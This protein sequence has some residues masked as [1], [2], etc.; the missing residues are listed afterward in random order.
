MT[1]IERRL[2]LAEALEKNAR[3]P[4]GMRFDLSV[5]IDGYDDGDNLPSRSQDYALDCGTVG[6]AVGLAMLLPEFRAEG[7][8]IVNISPFFEN[9]SQWSAVAKFFGVSIEEAQHLFSVNAYDGPTRGA[10][11]EFAVAK[12]LRESCVSHTPELVS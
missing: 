3:D 5:W 6:C 1:P 10:D 7:L 11:A 9:R 8:M 12:R 2:F 4:N